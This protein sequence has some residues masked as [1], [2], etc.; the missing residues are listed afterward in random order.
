MPDTTSS[1]LVTSKR[2]IELK[3][4]HIQEQGKIRLDIITT[5]LLVQ[6][7]GKMREIAL[8]TVQLPVLALGGTNIANA[9]I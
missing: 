3:W 2:R 4:V 8:V 7:T 1:R 9:L 5:C 6:K